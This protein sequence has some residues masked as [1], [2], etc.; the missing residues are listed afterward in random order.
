MRRHL[1]AI[2]AAKIGKYVF[3]RKG[4]V[5]LTNDEWTL[6]ERC[7]PIVFSSPGE[8][9][10]KSTD[11][12]RM[13]GLAAAPFPCFSI[14]V[15]GDS[16]LAQ[17]NDEDGTNR[18]TIY[19]IL[20]IETAPTQFKFYILI[21]AYRGDNLIFGE[22]EPGMVGPFVEKYID[23]IRWEQLGMETTRQAVR[24]GVGNNKR[25]HRI[26]RIVHVVPKKYVKKEKAGELKHID[27]SH[28]F[29]VR[30]HWRKVSGALG[31]DRNGDYT[32]SGYTWVVDHERGP[33][34]LPLIKKTRLV[35]KSL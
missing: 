5:P 9:D 31:K 12:G 30:G 19:Y 8:G 27:F 28:R 11:D 25:T 14:E 7:Q 13:Y 18:L 32:V 20:A 23:R 17:I 26:R 2:E 15:A 1:E 33:E 6:F 10:L 35:D 24:L 34:H 16:A 21:T 29:N 3:A 22:P 4:V